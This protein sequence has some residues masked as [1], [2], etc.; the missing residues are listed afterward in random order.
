MADEPRDVFVTGLGTVSPYG[1]E[2]LLLHD[3]AESVASAIGEL[4]LFE[5]PGACEYAAEVPEFDS[6]PFLHSTQPY[7]DRTTALALAATRSAL[8]AAGIE[9]PLDESA[10]LT[11]IVYGSCWG[12]AGSIERFSE[13]ILNGRP[14]TAQGLLFL[15]SF[16]N[17]PAS[18]A[19][20]EYGLRGHSAVFAGSRLAGLWAL[21]HACEAIASGRA[22]RLLCVAAESLSPLR[23]HCMQSAGE[24]SPD[25]LPKPLLEDVKGTI[26]GEGACAL[27]L[28]SDES[29]RESGRA[30]LGRMLF[31]DCVGAEET[32]PLPAPAPELCYSA[33]PGIQWIDDRERRLLERLAAKEVHNLVPL[34]GDAASVTPLFAM[35]CLLLGQD[36]ESAFV[37]AGAEGAGL[38]LLERCL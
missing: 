10:P 9:T 6:S 1:L 21:Q 20:I 26:P 27:L 12:C 2:P 3:G 25:G 36:R 8:D 11:G 5:P 29:L 14:K 4:T 34:H 17:T 37:Q 15:H 7:L 13:P 33:A 23:M 19:A 31:W 35:V 16:P 24:L 32:L 18:L 30:A 22:E 38:V 28:E